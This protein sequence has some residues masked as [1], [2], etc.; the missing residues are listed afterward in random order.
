MAKK[1][2]KEV[3]LVCSA[4][5]T[6]YLDD[7]PTFLLVTIT[8][9][10]IK[11]I[12]KYQNFLK[13]MVKA[14][15]DPQE[16]K[17]FNYAIQFKNPAGHNVLNKEEAAS[18]MFLDL[19]VKKDWLESFEDPRFEGADSTLEELEDEGW[20]SGNTPDRT[21]LAVSADGVMFDTFVKDTSV[22]VDTGIIPNAMLKKIAN[23]LG[24]IP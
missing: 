11:N 13:K 21:M 1:A 14:K 8:P 12:A 4:Q 20:G 24:V 3:H 19:Y 17:E 15:L 10:D 18:L 7:A 9:Q 2:L 16:I 6:G 5:V 23:K 22:I